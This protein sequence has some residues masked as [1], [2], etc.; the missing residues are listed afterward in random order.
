MWD[1]LEIVAGVLS[2]AHWQRF[3][4]NNFKSKETWRA[5][6][7]KQKDGEKLTVLH[8]FLLPHFAD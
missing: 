1:T 6:K 4:L 3:H 2:L 8:I 7:W 5:K